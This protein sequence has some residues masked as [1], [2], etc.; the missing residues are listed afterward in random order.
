[1][2]RTFPSGRFPEREK[3][4]K[5]ESSIKVLKGL[6]FAVYCWLQLG[7]MQMTRTPVIILPDVKVLIASLFLA[8]AGVLLLKKK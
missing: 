8:V 5:Y 1:M 7:D 2:K 4:L 3:R 6:L